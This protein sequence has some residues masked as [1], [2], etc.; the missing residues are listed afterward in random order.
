MKSAEAAAIKALIKKKRAAL[1]KLKDQEAELRKLQA[2]VAAVPK[3]AADLAAAERTLRMLNKEE[4]AEPEAQTQL[5]EIMKA[6]RATTIIRQD[7]IPSLVYSVLK[8][9]GKPQTSDQ[10]MP[11]LAAR[12]RT[13][14]KT[15][16]L[17]SIYRCIKKG[18]LFRLIAPGT[19]GL[20][21]WKE[22]TK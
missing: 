10:I 5:P 20:L 14:A 1:E 22:Q 6:I 21:E 8:E 16:V 4:E 15:T 9:A 11:L 3:V 17:G 12:G 2:A 13:A 7:S 18:Q 19:F